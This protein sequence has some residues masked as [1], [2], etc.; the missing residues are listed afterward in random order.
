M[1]SPQLYSIHNPEF[2]MEQNFGGRDL[3]LGR[4]VSPW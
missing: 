3:V 1:A 4:E 2:F